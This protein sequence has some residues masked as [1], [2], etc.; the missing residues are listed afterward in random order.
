MPLGKKTS[1]LCGVL[2]TSFALSACGGSSS[3][4]VTPAAYVKSICQSIGPF[5]KD[6]SARSNALNFGSITSPAQGKTALQGFLAAIASDT[7]QAVSK[8]KSAG[9]PNV[10]NGK[11]I[12][13]AIVS[14]FTQLRGALGQ[15]SAS[16]NQLPTSSPT[17]FRSAAVTLGNTVR[18]SMN[19]IGAG[20]AGLKSPQLEAAA[21]KE[22]TCQHLGR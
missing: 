10:N 19:G 15:A 2:A 12:S 8:L 4:T 18:G 1:T 11:K 22:Q 7:D 9:T 17:A 5:E 13:T 20:L 6:V 14:A 3:S 16:A 21:K